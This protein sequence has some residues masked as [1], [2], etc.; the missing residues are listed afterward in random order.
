MEIEITV[1]RVK[2]AIAVLVALIFALGFG[3]GYWVFT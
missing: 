1:G 3:V 2:F